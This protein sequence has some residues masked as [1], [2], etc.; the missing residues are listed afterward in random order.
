M[1]LSRWASPCFYRSIFD[2]V[3][4]MKQDEALTG[5]RKHLR[6]HLKP[7]LLIIDDMGIKR[8]PPKS[9]EHL[10]EIIMRRYELAPPS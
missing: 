3:G 5:T 6:S 1:R 8:L 2:V 9:G 7:D 4:D 10:F